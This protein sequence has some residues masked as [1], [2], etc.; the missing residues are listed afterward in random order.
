MKFGVITKTSE[1]DYAIAM[2]LKLQQGN[3]PLQLT[4]PAPALLILSRMPVFA[5]GEIL[6]LDDDGREI[7][8]HGR[9]PSK[10]AV[11]CEEFDTI[12]EALTRLFRGDVIETE[13]GTNCD[14]S[15]A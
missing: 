9:K 5:V 14:E 11:T 4:D 6:I 12:E 8:G 10:W 1:I 3:D 13:T 15:D 7:A 2:G